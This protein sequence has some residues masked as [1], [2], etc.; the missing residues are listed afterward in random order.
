MV[1]RLFRALHMYVRPATME[2]IK[3]GSLYNQSAMADSINN[4]KIQ[5]EI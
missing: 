1:E 5:L 3:S 2:Q 4:V